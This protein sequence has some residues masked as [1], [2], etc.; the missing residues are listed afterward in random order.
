MAGA[1]P[2]PAIPQDDPIEAQ[3]ILCLATT[4]LV[5]EGP[6]ELA[7]LDE[8]FALDR[9][10]Q[11]VSKLLL[12]RYIEGDG[13]LRTFDWRAWQAAIRLCQA[14]YQAHEYFIQYIRGTN[15]ANWTKHEPL[16][17]VQMFH[18]RKVEFLLRFFRYKKR[19]SGQWRELHAMY[20][21]SPDADLSHRPEVRR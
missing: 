15:D 20:L 17:L 11:S 1:G 8:L 2:S 21:A 9:Q 19:N 16:V 13:R 7:Q 10:G 3:R 14:F 4:L 5:Q 6:P 12:T 18:H